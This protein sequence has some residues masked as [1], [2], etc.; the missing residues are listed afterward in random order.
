MPSHD[1]LDDVQHVGEQGQDGER[2]L[3]PGERH[4]HDGVDEEGGRT[5]IR[6]PA[7]GGGW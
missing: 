4:H 6:A 2:N 1:E 3:P 7:P 5:S